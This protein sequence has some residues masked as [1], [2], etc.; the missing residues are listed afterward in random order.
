MK[1][2]FLAAAL[3]LMGTAVASSAQEA[4]EIRIYIN[5]GH[6][7]WGPNNRHMATIG[8]SPI[9]SENPDTTDFFESSTNLWKCLELFHRLKSYGFQHEGENA[10]DL[11]QNLV[12]SRIVNGPYPYDGSDY[13]DSGNDISLPLMEI[14]RTVEENEFDMFIS[15]HSNAAGNDGNSVNYL[16]FAWYDEYGSDS[17]TSIAMSEKGWDHRIRDRHT[18]WTHYDNPVGEG[19]VKIG[20]QELGVL[21]HT[22]P[23]FLVEGYFHTYHPARHRA[24]NRD[25]CRLEGVDY[26]RGIADYF[27]IPTEETGE[28]YGVVRD[29]HEKFSHDL[30][31]PHTGSN[32][33]FLPLNGMVVKLMQGDEV[34]ATY[35]T[36]NNYNGAFVFMNLA[37][38]TYTLA[39]EHP[40]YDC[41][42]TEEVVV[43]AS[44]ISYP[45]VFLTD[46]YYYSGRPGEEL[47][48][49]NLV[50]ADVATLA[51]RYEL[52]RDYV[53]KSVASLEGKTPK[54]MIWMRDKLYVLAHSADSVATVSVINPANG[55][56]LANVSTAACKGTLLDLS[57]IAVTADGTLLGC[58]KSKN[59]YSDKYVD[60]G[61]SRGEVI[62]YKWANDA[63][64]V[65]TG[66]AEVWFTSQLAGDWYRAYI[67]DSFAYTGTMS[68]GVMVVSS[69]S[70]AS[71]TA[72]RFTAYSIVD[73]EN[74]AETEEASRPSTLNGKDLG[75]AWLF[76]VS[77]IDRNQFLVTETGEKY[78][79]RSYD[80][81]H[82]TSKAAIEETPDDFEKSTVGT[83]FF[84]YAN[85]SVMTLAST[86]NN[87]R[88]FNISKG[89]AFANEIELANVEVDGTAAKALSTG[90]P[91]A[92]V[93]DS[94]NVVSGDFALLLLRDAKL[95][96]FTTAEVT[97]IGSISI[98]KEAPVR[99]YDLNG[100]SVDSSRLIPG[101]YI[102]LQGSEASK[103]I[104]K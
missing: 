95:S 20:S 33:C 11:E 85:E 50:S 99:Y 77:P 69:V 42:Q 94:G 90:Y 70:T 23:G 104:V 57:D 84:H 32:D 103:V 5:P 71:N 13:A 35:T 79:I 39:F 55:E 56:V 9:S 88:M 54:R 12:M 48:Y 98:D 43:E 51:E 15:V 65:P 52:N 61:E 14:A 89:L 3:M 31:V 78:G 96:R 82:E 26:A 6:G 76:S 72:M 25:V 66:E 38:G 100:R 28:I 45:A 60:E 37:P 87:L 75:D 2:K 10:L 47:N 93:D 21:K 18:D 24:M 83:G 1:F 19:T 16:Y 62:F 44:K 97:G 80:F 27:E 68:K 74:V 17:E 8:H 40:D 64:G 101:I 34:I 91:I 7:S 22:V 58:S 59:Q 46:K 86:D 4:E 36:D 102:R 63:N 29:A 49:V 81:Y 73:G 92:N 53:E 67:G 41:T 30:Y